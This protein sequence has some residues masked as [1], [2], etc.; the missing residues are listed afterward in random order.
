MVLV[1]LLATI[2]YFCSLIRHEGITLNYAPKLLWENAFR[3]ISS[4]LQEGYRV[5]SPI[6]HYSASWNW[7]DFVT[8]PLN[9][10]FDDED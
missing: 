6:R 10:T 5:I 3:P 7:S 4:I 2:W 8:I 1:V 9:G